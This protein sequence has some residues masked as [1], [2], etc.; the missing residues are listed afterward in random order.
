LPE[1]VA[2]ACEN[3]VDLIITHH[4]LIFKPITHINVSRMEGHVIQMALNHSVAVFSAHTNLD[5]VND[6]VNDILSSRIG[7]QRI[8]PLSM[9]SDSEAPGFGRIGELVEP[10]Q[11][12][13]LAHKL[14]RRLNIKNVKVAGNLD[15]L[16]QR[17]MVCSGSGSSLINAFLTSDTDVYISGDLRYHDARMIEYAQKALIDIGHFASEHLIVETFSQQLKT[18]FEQRGWS[19]TTEAYT[20]EE[21]PFVII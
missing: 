16:A 7:L 1:V 18:Q 19:L 9:D 10:M 14:K 20:L 15:L 5:R 6:G 11:I 13:K 3:D 2:D 17:V 21:D 12:D 4:P 8:Q